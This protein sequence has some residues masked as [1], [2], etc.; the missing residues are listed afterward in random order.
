MRIT[1]IH[2]AGAGDGDYDRD[3]LLALIRLHGHQVEYFA[4]GDDWRS[5][6][7]SAVELIVAAGGDG[8]VA[9]VGRQLV[10][11]NIPIAVLPLGTANNV[12]SELGIATTPIPQL[13]SGWTSAERRTFD[14]GRATTQDEILRFM[15]SAG[16][17]LLT[18]AIAEIT[19]GR[20]GYVNEL[21]GARARMDAAMDVLRGRLRRL[22]PTHI[23]L[24]IDGQ[25]ISGD[26]LLLEVMNFGWAG[27]NLRLAPGA[28]RADGLFDVVLADVSH[29]EQ[30]LED[31]P[32]FGRPNL[33]YFS[34]ADLPGTECDPEF[35]R[36]PAPSR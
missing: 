2:N 3:S 26:Y 9:E 13:V 6:A 1:L 20:A 29:R 16:V 31:L 14:T 10:G 35:G 34:A 25:R 30:L 4:S 28:D 15:E 36:V 21:D 5:A 18:E 12:A 11:S 17:G 22:E 27:P 33:R 24:V 23:E 7:R 8:T 32:L 19:E